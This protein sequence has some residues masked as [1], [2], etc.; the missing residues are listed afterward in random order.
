MKIRW[1]K[2]GT[3]GKLLSFSIFYPSSYYPWFFPSVCLS[4]KNFLLQVLVGKFLI[5]RRTSVSCIMV[6][7]FMNFILPSKVLQKYLE[8]VI[9]TFWQQAQRMS[10]NLWPMARDYR[11]P[12]AN[13]LEVSMMFWRKRWKKL[14]CRQSPMPFGKFANGLPIPSSFRMMALNTSCNYCQRILNNTLRNG[15]ICLPKPWSSF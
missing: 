7:C 9:N 6:I 14:I 10:S 13:F 12:L 2:S 1:P 8:N 4:L 15:A 5:R 11:H 3:E